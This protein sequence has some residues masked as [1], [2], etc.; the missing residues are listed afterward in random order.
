MNAAEKFLK[1][2]FLFRN[3]FYLF[4]IPWLISIAY[5][6]WIATDF[7][8]SES[9]FVLRTQSK[10][11]S[12][13]VLSAILPNSGLTSSA[14]DAYIVRDYLYSR[15]ALNELQKSIDFRKIFTEANVDIFQRYPLFLQGD[16]LE[17][18]YK[19]YRRNLSVEIGSSAN[20]LTLRI[21][22]PDPISAQQ[23][24][25]V[26]LQM[27]EKLV[28]RMSD[29]ARRDVVANAIEEVR[30]L[31]AKVKLQSA[32]LSQYRNQRN[33]FDPERQSIIQLNA[34]AR[35]QDELLVA[36]VQ[37]QQVTATSPLN[38]QVGSLQLKVKLIEDEI[39]R[40]KSK[41][42]GGER[43]LSSSQADFD[44][45]TLDKGITERQL[46]SA[47]TA[48]DTARAEAQRK[49]IY[50]ERL[51]EPNLSD[52]AESPQRIKSILSSAILCLLLWGVVMLVR[53]AILEHQ[54]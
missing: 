1:R 25:Q 50:L 28:N 47:V 21:K 15:D 48:L 10:I 5:F 26:L 17:T 27:S 49:S 39:T 14:E 24:N 16:N 12:S 41:I 53:S 43:S 42:S 54:S 2:G 18:L 9:K 13:G 23:A 45:L 44:R 34:I 46:A 29:K 6:G 38:S 52:D 35:L 51:V 40:E 11:G 33:L 8:S 32:A 30:L 4:L 3:H 31:E 19:L 22:M 36:K 20:I 37:L 7:F